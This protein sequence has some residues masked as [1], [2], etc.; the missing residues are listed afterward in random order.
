MTKI[1]DYI[2]N[3]GK[4]V[5]YSTIDK[6]QEIAPATSEFVQS[7]EQLFKEIVTSVRDYKNTYKS[8]NEAIKASKIYGA[9]DLL[10]KSAIS[11]IRTG[12]L[13][14]KER[15]DKVNSDILG[16]FD[17]EDYDTDFDIND[18]ITPP[19]G[20]SKSSS[21]ISK[22]LND[23]SYNNAIAV[24]STIAKTGQSIM[25]TNKASTNLLYSQSVQ[26]YNMFGHNFNNLNKNI[27]NLLQFDN[28]VLKVHAENSKRFYDEI[29]TG[30]KAEVQLLK[31]IRDVLKPSD[32]MKS[33][34]SKRNQN[35]V[36][37]SDL[38]GAEG[39]INIKDY[40]GNI[41]KN[42][43]NEF[44]SYL[45]SAK[46]MG[47]DENQS[48]LS[49]FA[50]S[51]LKLIP[52]MIVNKL[53]PDTLDKTMKQFDK[54]LSG[55][56]GSMI[57]KFNRMSTD[58]NSNI[59]VQTLGRIF[60]IE[61]NLKSGIDTSKYEKGRVN[62]TG[63][64][65]K[66]LEEVLPTQLGK[67]IAL[68][69]GKEEE[70]FNYETG[71]FVKYGSIKSNFKN[72]LGFY[73][74]AGTA[75]MKDEFMKYASFLTFESAEE[76]KEFQKDM[77]NFFNSLYNK[78]GFFDVN[79]KNINDQYT[80][81]GVSN[82]R[83][84]KMFKTMF[85]NTNRSTQLKLNSD[86]L[87]QRSMQSQYLRQIEQEG[88]SIFG[89]LSNDS[90]SIVTKSKSGKVTNPI[91]RLQIK[92]MVDTKGHNIFDYLQSIYKELTFMRRSVFGST[93]NNISSSAVP[94]ASN[95]ESESLSFNDIKIPYTNKKINE[96]HRRNNRYTREDTSNERENIRKQR[97]ASQSG[98]KIYNIKSYSDPDDLERQ[99][100][101]TIRRNNLND[102][103]KTKKAKEKAKE[104]S[105]IDEL[106]EANAV[107]GK[108]GVVINKLNALSKKPLDFFTKTLNKVD[109]RL[110]QIVYGDEQKN[111]DLDPKGFLNMLIW[112][113]E[114]TFARVNTW[115]D[116]HIL[117][118][119]KNKLNVKNMKD[120]SKKILGAFGIDA[121]ELS[122]N[123]K[124][125]LFGNKSTGEKGIFGSTIEATKDAFKGAF[126]TVKDSFKDT[127]SPIINKVK[128]SLNSKDEDLNSYMNKINNDIATKST[129]G[130]IEKNIKPNIE[131]S[132]HDKNQ[133]M[134]QKLFT[135]NNAWNDYLNK[136][137]PKNN[138]KPQ[139]TKEYMQSVYEKYK[140]LENDGHF[141]EPESRN[142]E[143][144]YL[145]QTAKK[146][147][148]RKALFNKKNPKILHNEKSNTS[149]VKTDTVN[150]IQE[151]V[152]SKEGFLSKIQKDISSIRD[153]ISKLFGSSNNIPVTKSGIATPFNKSIVK[154]SGET[155]V[156]NK[157]GSGLN[158]VIMDYLQKN[159]HPHAEGV[160]NIDEPELA[161]LSKGE[162]VVKK[163]GSIK[164]ILNDISSKGKK[165]GDSVLNELT[166][167]LN[168]VFNK[169]GNAGVIDRLKDSKIKDI[170]LK[171]DPQSR[172]KIIDRIKA[173]GKKAN[174]AT[175][176]EQGES[177]IVD[178]AKE[179]YN[180]AV[181]ARGVLFGEPKEDSKKFGEVLGDVTK[182]FGKYAP[183]AI[184]SGLLGAGV[185][186]VTGAIGGPLLG[187]AVGA[188]ISLTKSS[189]RI[190]D[191][192]FG[193]VGKDNKRSGG[194]ISQK[195]Q[196]V[197]KKFFPD[198]KR[199]GIVGGIAGLTPFLPFG[200]VAGLMLGA[201][202][203]F[204]KNTS[205]VQERL[206]GKNGI[207]NKGSQNKIKKMVPRTLAAL[208]PT[209]FLGPFG[210]LGNA[211]LGTGLGM[212]SNTNGF[213]KA[214]FGTPN[215]ITGQNENGLLPTVRDTIVNP[216]KKF[217]D[218]MANTLFDWVKEKIM[219]PLESAMKPLSKQIE[220]TLKN[221]FMGIGKSIDNMFEKSVG[222]PLSR[223]V[224]DKIVKPVTSLFGK[225]FNVLMAP[226]K[227]VVSSP[228]KL[229][230]A[231]GN[232]ARK[233]QVRNGYADYMTAEER[234][235]YR[236]NNDVRS[237]K[238]K[239][240]D[241]L[242]IGGLSKERKTTKQF[243]EFDNI[244]SMMDSSEIDKAYSGINTI[245][246]SRKAAEKNRRDIRDEMG[247]QI[248]GYL[249]NYK[250]SKNTMK[251]ILDGDMDSARDV[252]AKKRGLEKKSSSKVINKINNFIETGDGSLD[253]SKLIKYIQKN[254][255]DPVVA[256]QMYKLT[257]NKDYTKLLGL[258]NSEE[259]KKDLAEKNMISYINTRG[260]A[261]TRAANQKK[262]QSELEQEAYDQLSALGL[263]GINKDNAYKYMD[264]LSNERKARDAKSS[265][266]T[267]AEG[268]KSTFTIDKG[269]KDLTD[270]ERE[271][272]KD[273]MTEIEKLLSTL[274][275]IKNSSIKNNITEYN[276]SAEESTNIANLGNKKFNKFSPRVDKFKNKL[277]E[278]ADTEAG[279]KR[280]NKENQDLKNHGISI[281][282][283][284]TQKYNGGVVEKTGIGTVS[285]GEYVY[286]PE[287]TN[288][289]MGSLPDYLAKGSNNKSD[290]IDKIDSIENK[291]SS[292]DS[293]TKAE[294]DE[295]NKPVTKIDSFGNVM[296]FNKVKNGDLEPDLS[297]NNTKAAIEKS[298]ENEA[299]Q[300][301]ILTKLSSIFN[302]FSKK[303]KGED[304]E[305]DPKKKKKSFLGK[306]LSGLTESG[307]LKKIAIGLGLTA[308]VGAI[309]KYLS[310]PGKE[311]GK[312]KGDELKV[313]GENLWD[314][315]IQPWLKK[316]A[317][318]FI[319]EKVIPAISSGI[320]YAL[321]D[322]MPFIV[323]GVA[324]SVQF[325]VTK[326]YPALL[327]AV[328]AQMGMSGK[329]GEESLPGN[330]AYAVSRD[331]LVNGGQNLSK[332]GAKYGKDTLSD[333]PKA[334]DIFTSP[335]KAAVK[336][337]T[338]ATKASAKLGAKGLGKFAS[339]I[340]KPIAGI[341]KSI[342]KIKLF[343]KIPSLNNI[344]NK[345]T[346]K[347][348]NATI[349]ISEKLKSKAGIVG[350]LD[351]ATEKGLEK[352]AGSGVLKT[353]IQDFQEFL[354]KVLGSSP[355]VK[356][357]GADGAETLSSK[358]V[359]RFIE[360]VSK[361]IEKKGL[362]ITGK[363]AA[364][365]S[366]AGL[367]NIAFAVQ[368]FI[369]G[370]NNSRSILGITD[371]ATFTEKIVT[372]L[373]EAISNGFIITSLIPSKILVNLALDIILP[374]FGQSKTKIQKQRADARKK[375]EAYNKKNHT[376]YDVEQ[377][378][379]KVQGDES[380][381]AK[382]KDGVKNNFKY[383]KNG[384]KNNATYVKNGIVNNA[385]YAKNQIGKGVNFVKEHG[386][387][388]TGEYIAEGLSDSIKSLGEGIGKKISPLL[389]GVKDLLSY[390]SKL[391]STGASSAWNLSLTDYL[392]EPA[393]NSKEFGGFKKVMFYSNR[394]L[395]APIYGS[396][397]LGKGIYKGVSSIVNS[398]KGLLSYTQ[399]LGKSG[400]DKSWNLDWSG[401]WKAPEQNGPVSGFKK[402]MFYTNR[403]LGAPVYG[404]VA[405]GGAVYKGITGIISSGK[406]TYT[407][408]KKD[409]SNVSDMVDNASD[410][411][412]K[413]PEDNGF[414]GGFKKFIYATNR[415]LHAPS[416]YIHKLIKDLDLSKLGEKIK[417]W[418]TNKQTDFQNGLNGESSDTSNGNDPNKPDNN[419]SNDT[420]SS[421][422]N[423]AGKIIYKAGQTVKWAKNKVSNAA[424]DVASFAK[425]LLGFGG[426]G[427]G[428]LTPAQYKKLTTDSRYKQNPDLVYKL[429]GFN[430]KK[431]NDTFTPLYNKNNKGIGG[432][433]GITN[434]KYIYGTPQYNKANN[435]NKRSSNIIRQVK[436]AGSKNRFYNKP[437]EII[438]KSNY[439]IG[440]TSLSQFKI[441]T[442]SISSAVE[443]LRP[444]VDKY[445]SQYGV[446]DTD[447]VL[448]I[449][450]QEAGGTPSALRT[451]PMQ[452]SESLGMSAGA[453]S[454]Q[455][456]SI[457]AGLKLLG[458]N[459][460]RTGGDIPLSL[461]SYN[462]GG[463]FIDYVKSRGGIWTQQLV[464]SFR[465]AHG[466]AYGD[467]NYV[468]NVLRYYHGDGSG[469]GSGTTSDSSSDSKPTLSSMVSDFDNL[470]THT[471]N[472]FFGF[473][474]ST[475]SSS[476]SSSS[477]GVGS[478]TKVNLNSA[479]PANDFFTKTMN[480]SISSPYGARSSGFHYGIDVAGKQGTKIYS[481]INGTVAANQG[482]S[483]SGGF[484]NVVYVRDQKGNYNIFGHLA[485]R[486]K[487]SVGATVQQGTLIGNE[488]STGRSTGP[489]LHYEVRKGS[490]APGN[491]T[492]PN[493]YLKS[494][495]K[496]ASGGQF[497][498]QA[499]KAT[500]NAIKY[501]QGK[502]NPVPVKSNPDLAKIKK[503]NKSMLKNTGGQDNSIIKSGSLEKLIGTIITILSTIADNT[504][505]LT[506]IVKLLS[507]GNSNVDKSALNNLDTS[508]GR[509]QVANALK[510]N[511]LNDDNNS[512]TTAEIMKTINGIITE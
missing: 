289:I 425:N 383:V 77:Y 161:T 494:Y 75:S 419:K 202:A 151:A 339:I 458:E 319:T 158:N 479:T 264:M 327:K 475:D 250:L 10:I 94:S 357:V 228:F 451:D 506:T 388:G 169:E 435:L 281:N 408:I 436:N 411:Y 208:V 335:T 363:L 186:L 148:N 255:E 358:F 196:D 257:V 469:A 370:Y 314:K 25:E 489:H 381:W 326:M 299:N 192:L 377:Y 420:K 240:M 439:G 262:S 239:A 269:I 368:G 353:L 195:T 30:Q 470:L 265:T 78:G 39:T 418:F 249:K 210:L 407:D 19:S 447:L 109:E 402:F 3:L 16:N 65:A 227:A 230:G 310:T 225:L 399:G 113:T 446:N 312:T 413:I 245:R 331:V 361:Q 378:N 454:S 134:Y 123:V 177:V 468:Q 218:R 68:L 317:G 181:K 175:T 237:L 268:E 429:P 204:L 69:S 70:R 211:V 387:V 106:L 292:I 424:S 474:D 374:L 417:G 431:T 47:G 392:K 185:S 14:N 472:R 323:K 182:N 125:F 271:Q 92:N 401:Y 12:K 51:P 338:K 286:T 93:S 159:V 384:I 90:G 143:E 433:I 156:L 412:W 483:E 348:L 343:G 438:G 395:G 44:G 273:L 267:D 212:L 324:S 84:F 26:M 48:I 356:L 87:Q 226:V 59:V 511:F 480:A 157:F 116:D 2:K 507:S 409:N 119:I 450:M 296:K 83:N 316:D 330:A 347:G 126:G 311:E 461:Q 278:S 124:G 251:S 160:E 280:K 491:S 58:D 501:P 241:F 313:F 91:D 50:S 138:N 337:T 222:V 4:S 188:G 29:T 112:K 375:V 307:F 342:D 100:S 512:L 209:M 498:S 367:M 463:G 174:D 144:Y 301:G 213:Q 1:S 214:V 242:K 382:F 496:N 300:K 261:Y 80:D 258:I 449:I 500:L 220:I 117:K 369:S 54:S 140:S 421:I 455:D 270:Q 510:K 107:S 128:G 288:K 400:V 76:K 55:F 482:P 253:R 272:H 315:K 252:I 28:E 33:Q 171:V 199:L 325:A 263:S 345:V 153:M 346:D 184:G 96:M 217:Y 390:N 95:N 167:K 61:P 20:K 8:A 18:D 99:L 359:P 244:L 297:D 172:K 63:K 71:K 308:G 207:I 243:S 457:Q 247:N 108:I 201:G 309:G 163:G 386:L 293:N 139:G 362:A 284:A 478:N 365:I 403:I 149:K 52:A 132:E 82:L 302:V 35:R 34:L 36:S 89:N 393:N 466:G 294:A 505:N 216:V 333:I 206:F 197:F 147:V 492:E 187:A 137:Y 98:R 141:D 456:R 379:K 104:P 448:A 340:G 481:P 366:T 170:L 180:A 24:S 152:T 488:G 336:V 105:L 497:V 194:L 282:R 453:L 503:E 415:V 234:N 146:Y 275:D 215:K 178:A 464:D 127:F 232:A 191:W 476:T 37:F 111:G 32:K 219:A 248:T 442:Q 328:L 231:L 394:I 462:F 473:D 164:D 31:E 318:P 81:Y 259:K 205:T 295:L 423:K 484:G 422:P 22:A 97:N 102:K 471:Q 430:A 444:K 364:S 277:E 43:E 56:F 373:I 136:F 224:E 41:K 79:N 131:K 121:D 150:K 351:K 46:M 291:L 350:G 344:S 397:A 66:A 334:S 86:I 304:D 110:Y 23:S 6:I 190:K 221:V 499:V 385:K 129:K 115:V 13:Y 404:T 389:S 495:Y 306:L 391:N 198:M 233:S 223:L 445:K 305:D 62:W 15:E 200:P 428:Y 460:S 235:E 88:N 166:N 266:I 236:D 238:Q 355:V 193:D 254:V 21:L 283:I 332:F 60:G 155:G 135:S 414:F 452:S 45:P 274:N 189:D 103:I 371:K 380:L 372:G 85:K 486:S 130:A 57:S 349:G 5:A 72:Q 142:T 73:S 493:A 490:M 53:I 303:K 434:P 173:T 322:G 427:D 114:N 459:L 229:I 49:A 376:N 290:L 122:K 38:V 465:A 256:K 508:T 279:E 485:D 203:G 477:G 145:Y 426:Q 360:G 467:R 64:S 67:I 176:N 509:E 416:Y 260:K 405:L 487:L 165:V 320:R 40:A 154:T 133:D 406:E 437:Q 27:A 354:L 398:F 168:S 9:G 118:P 329:N 410:N 11:D 42:I 17:D 7:N 287:D 276:K 504:N 183:K 120:L 179:T 246:D 441:G 101:Y 285:K 352:T 432:G 396:I 502:V 162:T 443:A 298:K 321:T 341:E 440:G 74:S